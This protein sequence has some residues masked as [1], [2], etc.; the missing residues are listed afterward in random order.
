MK[1]NHSRRDFLKMSATGVLGAVVLSQYSCKTGSS[2]VPAAAAVDPKTFGIGLQLYTIRDAMGT[3]VPGSLKKVSDMGYK[4]LE[5]AGYADGKFYGYEPVEFKKMVNDLGMEILSSHT[6][7]EALGITLDNAKKMAEDHAKLGV[8]Y[9]MQ[10]WVVEEARTTIAS[11]QKMCADWNQVGA[12]MKEN[13]IQFGYH[14]HNFE[15][16]TV[17][18]KIPYFD[19]FMVE[20]DKELV[21]MEPDLFWMSKAGQNPVEIFKKYP[22]RFQVFHMKD[23]YTKEAPFYTTA[24]VTD[25]APVGAGVID[26]KAILAAKDIAGMK[27]MV[28]EQD[29]TKDGKPF[30][31][32]Q[33]SITNLTTKIL[34]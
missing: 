3:D 13:G 19:V 10:P 31:A 7:V 6:Q 5:L 18:G 23:M 1:K 22:G 16:D 32:A 30:D 15:F 4:Y 2:K 14:N 33:T 20:L 26:F 21:T 27:Y 25:F 9:C 17:E 28:V 11:Y 29:R 24:G 34:V 12:I 8:K